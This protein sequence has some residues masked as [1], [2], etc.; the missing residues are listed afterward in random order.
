MKRIILT[1]FAILSV[2]YSLGQRKFGI[3]I[4]Q[5]T[6]IFETQYYV[7][8]DETIKFDIVNFDRFSFA[9]DIDSKNHFTH[10][11][12]ILIPEVE[13][14][15]GKI[16]F[17]MNYEFAR[18][19]TFE[20]RASS[21]SLRY[22]LSKTLLKET[23]GFNFDFGIGVNPFFLFIEYIRDGASTAF[24]SRRVHGFSVNVV[25]RISYKL[26]D[27]FIIDLNVPL[28]I[29]DL[30]KGYASYNLPLNPKR[31][32]DFYTINFFENVYTIRLGLM[33]KFDM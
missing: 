5:N 11:I 6:D 30:Y 10:E 14:P 27:R 26:N 17:P 1:L 8:N 7:G 24:R 18:G 16:Q 28:K 22:E 4:Y 3:K 2:I 19:A 33:Y 31:N 9:F 13:K 21:Y 15:L 29:Y 32:S 23:K 20:G 25:P 12:E